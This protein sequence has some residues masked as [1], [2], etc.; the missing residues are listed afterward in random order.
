M[1]NGVILP[2]GGDWVS[3]AQEYGAVPLDFSANVS[4]LGTPWGVQS[5]IAAV[6]QTADR[7]PD[8][9][10]RELRQAIA[11][12]EGVAPEQILCG[13]G[14]VELIYRAVLA[15]RPQRAL[16]LAPTFSEYESALDL[17]GCETVRYPLGEADGFVLREDILQ[18]ITPEIQMLFLCEPNN[19]TGRTTS[20]ELLWNIARRCRETG[21]TLVVDECFNPFLDEP[22]AHSLRDAL[23]EF[24]NLLLLKAFTKL[25]AMAGVRLGYALA[26]DSLLAALEGAGPPWSVS[27][28]AQ[29]AGLAA[30][31]ETAYVKTLR[32]LMQEQRPLLREGLEA[33]GLTVVPGEANYLLFRAGKPLYAPLRQRGFLLRDCGNYHNLHGNWYRAAVRTRMEN[34]ALLRALEEV[35]S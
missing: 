25:Y 27:S 35:L 33:L 23:G 3:F 17:A 11:R 8:P 18:S 2:H 5:A 19:P 32:A 16:V 21:T 15:R 9:L 34:Q 12:A 13:N 22:E 24:P 26:Q 4:P 30:L 7:Y 31:K 14:A 6:A 10:C 28:L 29:A 1:R 20:R